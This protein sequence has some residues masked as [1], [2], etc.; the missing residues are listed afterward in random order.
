LNENTVGPDA[1]TNPSG[2]V[3]RDVVAFVNNSEFN[4]INNLQGAQ[5]PEHQAELVPALVV[6]ATREG[7]RTII[8]II[9]LISF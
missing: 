8:E 5:A 3:A 1:E 2:T 9:V 6:Q 4:D 7:Y